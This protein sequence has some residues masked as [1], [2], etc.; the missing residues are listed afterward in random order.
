MCLGVICFTAV[1]PSRSPFTAPDLLFLPTSAPSSLSAVEDVRKVRHYSVST[2][3]GRESS[4]KIH[5]Y[6]LGQANGVA[7]VVHLLSSLCCK[8]AQLLEL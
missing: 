1:Q 5:R 4:E 6:S 3:M 2:N 8:I 7:P